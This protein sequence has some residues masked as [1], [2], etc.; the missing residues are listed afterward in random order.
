MLRHT[1]SPNH[2][3]LRGSRLTLRVFAACRC[4]PSPGDRGSPSSLSQPLP[5]QLLTLGTEPVGGVGGRWPQDLFPS[6]GSHCALS[7]LF[8][9]SFLLLSPHLLSLLFPFPSYL[10]LKVEGWEARLPRVTSGRECWK[11]I[12]FHFGFFFPSILCP[13]WKK[14]Q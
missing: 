6:Q 7:K 10:G 9:W 5:F 14:K 3:D 11:D 13:G 1:N 2:L 12:C 8:L 4:R